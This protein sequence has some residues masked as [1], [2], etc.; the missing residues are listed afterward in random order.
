MTPVAAPG[1]PRLRRTVL[2]VCLA[3]LAWFFVE[4]GVARGIGSVALFAD[5][6]D[7]LEDAAVNLLVFMALAWTPRQRA[8][9]GMLLAVLLLVPAAAALWTIGQKLLTPAPPEPW[10]LTGTAGGA[11]VVNLSCALALARFRE[12]SGSL[13]KAAFL[14]ARNDA[15]ANVAI[16]AAGI[17]TVF[18]RSAWPDVLVGAGIAAI[19]ADAALAVWRAARR[20]GS[21]PVRS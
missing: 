18:W 7:F 3:N 8:R 15:V 21:A 14:S 19:N 4:F 1:D 16:I 10:L 20:E 13:G 12:S 6:I 2:F 5:S 17:L 11:L 9:V